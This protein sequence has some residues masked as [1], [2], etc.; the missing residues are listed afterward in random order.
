MGPSRFP[1][2][3]SLVIAGLHAGCAAIV[4]AACAAILLAGCAAGGGPSTAPTPE[5]ST[6]LVTRQSPALSHVRPGETLLLVFGAT[7]CPIANGYAPELEAIHERCRALGWRAFYVYPD[8]TTS[9]EAAERHLADYGISMRVVL[10]PEHRVTEAVG[11]TVTPEAAIV[12][13]GPAEALA[14]PVPFEV[15]YRGRIDDQYPARGTRRVA[16]TVRDLRAAIEAVAAGRPADAAGGPPVGC[17]IEPLG[18]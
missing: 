17:V 10:D 4:P 1:L 12:R 7:D 15:L 14:G 11:A 18:R 3:T 8:P 2:V 6:I 13:V 9:A 16:P 5:P